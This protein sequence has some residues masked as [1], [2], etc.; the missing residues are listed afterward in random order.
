ME[1]KEFI[2]RKL[3]ASEILT[4]SQSIMEFPDLAY[5]K[6]ALL[7]SFDDVIVAEVNGQFAGFCAAEEYRGLKKLG[8]I[9][10]AKQYQGTGVGK[11]LMM[12]VFE[13]NRG[14]RVYLGT[15]NAKVKAF[16]R[17]FPVKEYPTYMSVPAEIRRAS[18][19]FLLE[20]FS[21]KYI[22]EGLRKRIQYGREKYV[23]FELQ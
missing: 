21:I 2:R 9:A 7:A 3:S 11:E 20:Y 13:E 10:L 4:I 18:L 6:P 22:F 17:Q 1:K 16:I 12:K 19:H 8:P 14:K 5:I 23:F 15:S